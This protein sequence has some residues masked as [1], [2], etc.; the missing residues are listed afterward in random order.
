[1][2]RR[3][4]FRPISRTFD[5]KTPFTFLQSANN[6]GAGEERVDESHVYVRGVGRL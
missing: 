2:L 6:K 5:D 4:L 1:M 3:L